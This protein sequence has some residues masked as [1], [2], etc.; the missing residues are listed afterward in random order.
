MQKILFVCLLLLLIQPLYSQ[1][2]ETEAKAA[3]I[4]AEENYGKGNYPIA[5][6]F[7]KKAKAKLDG[8]NC[9]ILYLQI[10][11]ESELSKTN[12]NYRDSLWQTINI[13]QSL[14]D[15]KDFTED[16]VLEVAKIK[17][18]IVQNL[19]D[20]AVQLAA[21][22][23]TENSRKNKYFKDYTFG[24]G[25][26]LGIMVQDAE[27]LNPAFFRRARREISQD[28]PGLEILT[29]K[30]VA[31]PTYT[32]TASIF[33]KNNR[34][35][36]NRFWVTYEKSDSKKNN[37]AYFRKWLVGE[38]EA[39]ARL[40]GFDPVIASSGDGIKYVWKKNKKTVIRNWKDVSKEGDGWF[41]YFI[42][43]AVDESL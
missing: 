43:E 21:Q 26:T 31:Y 2:N 23:A 15:V 29:A 36:G 32:S 8:A 1:V 10:Q 3:Y 40:F 38:M 30:P 24:E 7:L 5:L 4:L 14:P 22:K 18:E 37:Y 12:R 17:L 9:K 27:K 28:Y 33:I 39:V 42:S 19:E 11:I 34:I 6:S 20:E 25:F 35:V 41:G 13:F 16:K